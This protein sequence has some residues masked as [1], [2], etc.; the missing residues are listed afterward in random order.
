M[1][2]KTVQSKVEDKGNIL[3]SWEGMADADVARALFERAFARQPSAAELGYVVDYLASEKASGRTRRKALE[4]MLW[5][6]LVSKEF[7]LNH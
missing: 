3:V 1:N 6:T 4:G 2:G 7:Q 5:A